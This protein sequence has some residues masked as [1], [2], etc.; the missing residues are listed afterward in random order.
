MN[1]VRIRADVWAAIAAVLAAAV[2]GWGALRPT[3]SETWHLW[4]A[5]ALGLVSMVATS[6]SSY[7]A[8]RERERSRM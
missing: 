2:A 1:W 8:K 4:L 5:F 7:L 3:M 6:V